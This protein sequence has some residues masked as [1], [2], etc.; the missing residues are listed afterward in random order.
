VSQGRRAVWAGIGVALA[1]LLMVAGPAVGKRLTASDF[2]SNGDLIDGWYWLRDQAFQQ[3]AKWTFEGIPSETNDLTVEITARATGRSG[4]AAADEVRFRLVYG[5]PGSG[6]TEG[7]FEFQVVTL[8]ADTAGGVAVPMYSGKIT[9]SCAGFAAGSTFMFRAERESPGD[10]YT[11]FSA[12]SVVLSLPGVQSPDPLLETADADDFGATGDLIDGAFWCR[13]VGQFLQWQ[14]AP[15]QAS[16]AVLNAAVDFSLLVTTSSGAAS[17]LSAIADVTVLNGDGLVAE[18][19]T[20][21]LVNTFRPLFAGDSG[22]VGWMTTGAYKL[23][24]PSLIER[25][26]TIRI[27]LSGSAPPEAP[28]ETAGLVRRIGG[29]RS[30]AVLAYVVDA[31]QGGQTDAAVPATV[32]DVLSDPESFDGKRVT[33]EARFYGWNEGLCPCVPQTPSDWLIG[34]QQFYLYVSNGTVDGLPLWESLI[35]ERPIRVTGVVKASVQSESLAC[36]YLMLETVEL[37]EE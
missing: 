26:F 23:K 12:G 1:I 27:A 16:G 7:L 25:G 34:A 5:C 31:P 10:D 6:E 17:G 24:D 8:S 4:G 22:G 32:Y 36:P 30:S 15:H 13:K 14:W 33:I 37:R 29:D 20:V 9:V 11:A 35:F 19:G 3:Y 28:V 18:V 2:R 21:H